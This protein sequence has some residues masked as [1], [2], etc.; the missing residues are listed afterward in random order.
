MARWG[1]NQIGGSAHDG[2]SRIWPFKRMEGRQAYDTVLERLVFTHVWGPTTDTA[3]WKN[4]D[5]G[6]AISAGMAAAGKEYSG[7]FAFTDTYMYWPTTH[8]VAPAE[9]ALKCQACHAEDGRLAT[10]SGV[11]MP[12]T[13]NNAL[14][15]LLGKLAFLAALLGVSL[16]TAL[17]SVSPAICMAKRPASTSPQLNVRNST[18]ELWL[19]TNFHAVPLTKRPWHPVTRIKFDRPTRTPLN[20]ALGVPFVCRPLTSM[21]SNSTR[22]TPPSERKS[23][24]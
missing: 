21:P 8:M 2:K 24:I 7:E 9:E 12:G 10:I 15:G 19:R 5:W 13:G 17:V 20:L 22:V 14:V 23:H 16:N 6:K 11:F 18:V 1:V 3:F 4:F